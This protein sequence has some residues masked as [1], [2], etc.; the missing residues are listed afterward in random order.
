MLAVSLLLACVTGHLM[1]LSS[2]ISICGLKMSHHAPAFF[3]FPHE[4]FIRQKRQQSG[5]QNR[6]SSEDEDEPEI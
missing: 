2:V 3:I 5:E 6:T 1:S 4:E